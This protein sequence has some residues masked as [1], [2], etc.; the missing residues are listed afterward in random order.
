MQRVR[1]TVAVGLTSM[2]ALGLPTTASA[3]QLGLAFKLAGGAAHCVAVADP[4]CGSDVHPTIPDA[5]SHAAS[6]DVI[7]V[8]PGTYTGFFIGDGI[9]VRSSAGAGATTIVPP[10]VNPDGIVVSYGAATLEGFTVDSTGE[11][12]AAVTLVGAGSMVRDNVIVNSGPSRVGI[13][14]VPNIFGAAGGITVERNEISNFSVGVYFNRSASGNLFVSNGFTSN[15]I[16]ALAAG[17]D[18]GVTDNRFI[19]NRFTGNA[20]AARFETPEGSVVPNGVNTFRH[21]CFSGNVGGMR[22]EVGN[23]VQDAKANWWGASDGATGQGGSG[24]P[25]DAL[26]DASLPNEQCVPIL[27][28]PPIDPIFEAD[29]GAT[30][31]GPAVLFED[32][33]YRMWYSESSRIGVAR[34]PDGVTWVRGADLTFDGAPAKYQQPSVT[35]IGPTTLRLWWGSGNVSGTGTAPEDYQIFTAISADDGAT[36]GPASMVSFPAGIEPDRYQLHVLSGDGAAQG[37]LQAGGSLYRLDAADPS[38]STWTAATLITGI[39]ECPDVASTSCTSAMVTRDSAG[40]RLW[41]STYQ[42]ANTD[43]QDAIRYAVS[44]DGRR[45]FP[46][47]DPLLHA[48]DGVAW[49]SSRTTA[50][51]AIQRGRG[52]DVFFQGRDAS[53]VSAIGVATTGPLPLTVLDCDASLDDVAAVQQV[54]DAIGDGGTIALRGVCDLSSVGAAGAASDGSG[55]TT[56]ALVLPPGVDDLTIRSFDPL[57]PASLIGSGIQA[58]VYVAPGNRGAT[59]RD[60]RLVGFALPIVA[61]NSIGTTIGA[62]GQLSGNRIIGGPTTTDGILGLGSVRGPSVTVTDGMG[63]VRTFATTEAAALRNLRI[64]GNVVSIDAPG[65][66]ARGISVYQEQSGRIFD[67]EVRANAVGL[68]SSE[69]PSMNMVGVRVWGKAGNAAPAMIDG[70]EIAGNNLGRLE[71]LGLVSQDAADLQAAGRFGILVNRAANVSA[72]GNGIRVRLSP[73]PGLQMP[74]GGIVF[75]NV[76][77]GAVNDNGIIVV[78][79][80][81]TLAADFGAIGIIDRVSSLMASSGDGPAT[82]DITVTDNIIGFVASESD[83][84][85][86]A[87]GLVVNGASRISA[88]GNRFKEITDRSISIGAS[89]TGFGP[90]GS[91]PIMD[92]AQVKDSTFCGNWLNT[93]STAPADRDTPLS[94][95]SFVAGIGSSGNRFPGGQVHAGNAR[96]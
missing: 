54:I 52:F 76:D 89:L 58:G 31:T 27:I 78:T 51:W 39:P 87:K 37:F 11:T 82:R 20:T 70:V 50:P 48:D 9:T 13:G 65:A 5:M 59:I 61:H 73:T 72:D 12:G 19:A 26:A 33:T 86:A 40:Y 55:L 4:S 62:T 63:T 8:G 96:C 80:P 56:A 23:A 57:A 38:G 47:S 21:N 88:S 34:S 36:W 92:P 14:I 35:R 67:V 60:L 66:D 10:K 90:T 75:G 7:L 3:T 85:G 43:D 68:A 18:G 44:L 16:G 24:D 74:G 6:G 83:A 2:I 64:E 30:A 53:G 84:V 69:Y 71:E 95:I 45:F 77:G 28:E 49:R 81:T 17:G 41:Y 46:A 15:G 29:P 94:Q 93:T 42:A 32:G 22:V 1:A 79:D 25:A 91:A